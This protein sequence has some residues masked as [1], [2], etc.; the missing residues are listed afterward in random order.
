MTALKP[1]EKRLLIGLGVAAFLMA[2]LWGWSF[3]QGGIKRLQ[4]E[5]KRLDSDLAVLKSAQR[6]TGEARLFQE[7]LETHMKAYDSMDMRD[8][9]LGNFVEQCAEDHSLKLQKNN[10]LATELPR[11]ED[12]QGFIK[13][14]YQGEVA[15]SWQDVM[16]FIYGLQ[17][18][19]EFRF[20]KSLNLSVRKS[21]AQDGES[22]LVC[23]FVIQ[24][25]WHPLSE[26]LVREKTGGTAPPDE[27]KPAGSVPTP[28]DSAGAKPA[29]AEDRAAPVAEVEHAA[30]VTTAPPVPPASDVPPEQ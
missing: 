6:Q 5:G 13:S 30:P 17:E 12:S 14:G 27:Q 16:R 18:P 19:A 10:P 22:E 9:Y 8:T 3:F 23:Q 21:E 29:V 20:V 2:N 24:K 15:G 25:W 1:S 26:E 7:A 4:T 11:P 28:D